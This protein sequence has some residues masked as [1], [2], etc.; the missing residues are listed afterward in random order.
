[1]TEPE[2]ITP[3]RES[4]ERELASL[5]GQGLERTLRTVPGP[6]GVLSG[7][8]RRILNFSSNDYLGFSRH[9]RILAAAREAIDGYGAGSGASRL[10]TGTFPLHHELEQELARHKGY[11]AALMFGTGYMTNCGVIASV[12]DSGWTV[13]ADRQIHAS[14]IDAVRLSGARLVRFHHNDPADLARRLQARSAPETSL[15]LTES[16]FSMDG[17]LAPLVDIAHVCAN[18]GALLM[19][20]EAHATGIFGRHGRGLVAD[21]GLQHRVAFSMCTFSKALG[22]FGG[23][24]A[25][26]ESLKCWLVHKAR[27][28][29]YTTAPPP[30]SVAA[31]LAALRLLEAEADPGA[32][33]RKRSDDLRRLLREGGADTLASGSQIVPVMVGDNAAA[34]RIDLRLR[35]QGILAVA[36]RPPTVAPGSARLRLS[37]TLDHTPEDIE[38]AARAV[39][40]ALAAEKAS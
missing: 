29:I 24:V 11:P 22:S 6:G 3:L 21:L 39:L 16:V 35:E 30:A 28:F 4:V 31:T 20:D 14:M 36:L 17:D 8:R 12:C 15:V 2:H 23:A 1:M 5:R 38:C 7:D 27:A 37:V 9:P 26:D 25:L 40:A 32:T 18:A 19:V 10:V 33:V 13:F 34:V